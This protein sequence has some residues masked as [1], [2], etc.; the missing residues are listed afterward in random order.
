L[1][2]F[3]LDTYGSHWI[4][5]KMIT[6]IETQQFISEAD[7]II[8]AVEKDALFDLIARNP[9]KGDV[10]SGTGGVRKLRFAIKRKGKRGGGRVV[11]YY[12]NDRNPVLLFTL[13]GKNEKSNLTKKEKDILYGIIQEIKKEMKP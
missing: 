6:I 5:L 4:L 9:K 7:K 1:G 8:S 13:F 11:Y 2:L 3:I 10:I 12:Y